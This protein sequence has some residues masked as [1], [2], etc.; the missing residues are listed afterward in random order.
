MQTISWL[1]RYI[2]KEKH[3]GMLI[4]ILC[5]FFHFIFVL[6][7]HFPALCFGLDHYGS[8]PLICIFL[9]SAYA[10]PDYYPCTAPVCQLSI[11]WE[12]VKAKIAAEE[13][14]ERGGIEP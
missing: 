3:T 9:V 12:K 13:D 4:G 2:L 14:K 6:F 5:T 8:W 7:M 10:C 11:D 1:S